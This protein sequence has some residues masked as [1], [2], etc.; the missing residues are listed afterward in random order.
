[1]NTTPEKEDVFSYLDALRESGI[2]NMYGA[3]PYV[4]A[5]YGVDKYEARELCIEWADTFE[6][7]HGL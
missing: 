4:S 6:E 7:R 1:M 5:R 2:T 3:G